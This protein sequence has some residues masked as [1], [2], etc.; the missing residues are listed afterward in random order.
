MF[1]RLRY[2]FII[3]RSG[4]Y[5]AASKNSRSNFLEFESISSTRL[6]SGA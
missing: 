3:A 2:Y 4:C 6:A 1:Q 5:L